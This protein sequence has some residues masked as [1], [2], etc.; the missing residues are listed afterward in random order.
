MF[1]AQE[2]DGLLTYQDKK[3]E[4]H[5]KKSALERTGCQCSVEEGYTLC[6]H[7][8]QLMCVVK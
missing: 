5:Q 3:N 8:L 7:H 4:R 1:V 6:Y 2:I